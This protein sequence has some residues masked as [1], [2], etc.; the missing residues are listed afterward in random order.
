MLEDVVT[1]YALGSSKL[2]SGAWKSLEQIWLMEGA[3]M[4]DVKTWVNSQVIPAL[5]YQQGAQ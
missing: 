5:L 1:S 4:G 3:P 2:G